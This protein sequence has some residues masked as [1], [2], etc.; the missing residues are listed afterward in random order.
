[1]SPQQHRITIKCILSIGL[2]L[3]MNPNANPSHHW[4]SSELLE[5]STPPLK[6]N[7]GFF[8]N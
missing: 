7:I 3:L 8:K 4:Q 6:K 5:E 2:N 1:M